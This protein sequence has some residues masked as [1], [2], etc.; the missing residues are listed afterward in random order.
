MAAILLPA[1]EQKRTYQSFNA[2]VPFNFSI[3]DR[4]LHAGYYEF[5]VIGPGLMV[6]RDARAKVLAR[7]LTRPLQGQERETPPRFVFTNKEGHARLSSIWMEKGKEGYEILG[8]EVAMRPSNP[9][10]PATP[11][12]VGRPPEPRLPSTLH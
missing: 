3:G 4:K 6:M 2:N 11:L 5:V 7:L 8:E 12:I 9:G 10:T 1:Q